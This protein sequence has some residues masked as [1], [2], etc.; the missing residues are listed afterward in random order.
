MKKVIILISFLLF[1]ASVSTLEGADL[2]KYQNQSLGVTFDYP[3]AFAI[4]ENNSKDVPLSVVFSYGQAPFAVSIL[5]KEVM[6]SNN[7]EEF[8]KNE[9][10]DQRAGGYIAQIKEN[11]YTIEGKIPAIEFIRTSEIGTI[12]YFI[13][14]SQKADKLLAFWYITNKIVTSKI[15]A[16][17][18]ENTAK[19]YRIMKES[20]KIS[21]Q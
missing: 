8:I 1:G 12:Y 6:D 5:L 19:A 18:D 10:K 13:F 9:S 14:P 20:L 3:N 2:K 21:N 4:D 7:L 17:L 16:D 11:K 15:I